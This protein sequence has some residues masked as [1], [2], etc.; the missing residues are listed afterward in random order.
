METVMEVMNKKVIQFDENS[1]IYKI[2][3]ELGKYDVGCAI[4]TRNKK[5]VGIISITDISNRVVAEGK[6]PKK[7]KAKDIMTKNIFYKDIES[8]LSDTYVEM[9]KNNMIFCPVTQNNKLIGGVE[10]REV[11][12]KLSQIKLK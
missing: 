2:G 9:V 7:T 6:D 1:F 10:L 4:I 3:K 12:G 8:L 5:P 11:M